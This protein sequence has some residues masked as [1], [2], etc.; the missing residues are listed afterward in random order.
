MFGNMVSVK[1]R[2]VVGFGQLE[3]SFVIFLEG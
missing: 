1:T 2:L 3:A